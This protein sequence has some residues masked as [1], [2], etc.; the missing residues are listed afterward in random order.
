[1][2]V[3][4]WNIQNGGGRRIEGIARALSESGSDVCVL[5][6]YTNAS[7]PRLIAALRSH[8]YE[9]VLHTEPENRWGGVLVASRF[10]LRVGDIAGCPSPDRWLHVVVEGCALQIGAAYIPNAERSHTEKSEYW[11]W[12]LGVGEKMVHR[13]AIICGDFNTGLP[14]EDEN[15]KSLHC[16]EEMRQML[17]SQWTD[18]WRARHLKDRESSWWSNVGNGFR[19]DHAFG[20]TSI[21]SRCRSAEYLTVVNDQCVAHASRVH[22]DCE[23][24]PLSDHSM[25]VVDLD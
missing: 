17:A 4:A 19:L 23:Q 2:Q 10:P 6:E 7:S 15:G 5:S 25:L 3:S 14:F 22:V 9:H 1:M 12:L 21:D 24:K 16:A 8:G 20:T 18:L 11:K 13:D